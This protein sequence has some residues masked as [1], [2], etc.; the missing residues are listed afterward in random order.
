MLESFIDTL[1]QF[2]GDALFNVL[3]G[4]IALVLGFFVVKFFKFLTKKIL[5]RLP[6]GTTITSFLQSIIFVLIYIIYIMVVLGSFGIPVDG[7]FTLVASVGVAVGLALKDSLSNIANGILLVVMKPFKVGDYVNINGVE[8]TVIKIHLINTNIR[9]S[10]NKI[11]TVPNNEV[12]ADNIINYNG[13]T[14]RR[15]D[16]MFSAAYDADIELVKSTIL[17][18]ANNHPLVLKDPE[19]FCRLKEQG[20]SSLNYTL[21]LWVKASD[22]WT[23]Y[24]DLNEAVVKTFNEKNIEIPYNKLDVKVLN[25]EED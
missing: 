13:M 7:I 1:K 8:G 12:M 24:F 16:M 20:S 2:T 22:Y 3:A 6:I 18:L 5:N 17:E 25:H 11:I 21:R 14:T 23:V 10:D 4:L 9:T 15:L 19:P